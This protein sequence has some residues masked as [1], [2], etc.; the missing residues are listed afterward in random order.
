M[1][2][3]LLRQYNVACDFLGEAYEKIVLVL[4][5]YGLCTGPYLE[6]IKNGWIKFASQVIVRHSTEAT[7]KAWCVKWM[8]YKLCAFFAWMVDQPLPTCPAEFAGDVPGALVGGRVMKCLRVWKRE[9]WEHGDNVMKGKWLGLGQSLKLAKRGMPRPDELMAISTIVK[10]F[11][12][13]T[14]SPIIKQFP[15]VSLDADPT[16]AERSN[17]LRRLSSI[18]FEDERDIGL[19]HSLQYEDQYIRL[20]RWYVR[21]VMSDLDLSRCDDGRPRSLSRSATFISS[22]SGLGQ[23]GSIFG[24]EGNIQK[25][26]WDNL[27]LA[28]EFE[29]I[30]LPTDESIMPIYSVRVDRERTGLC[31]D[32]DAAGAYANY[33]FVQLQCLGR[34][35]RSVDEGSH[36]SILAPVI[37]ALKVRVI[38]KGSGDVVMLLK[39][40][41]DAMRRYLTGMGQ[42]IVGKI[43]DESNLAY[44]GFPDHQK[45]ERYLSVDYEDST[46]NLGQIWSREISEQIFG[47]CHVWEEKRS[48]WRQTLYGGRVKAAE[49]TDKKKAW[50]SRCGLGAVEQAEYDQCTVPT[51]MQNGQLMG[52]I[53]SFPI[54]CLAN[55]FAL[56]MTKM[57][58]DGRWYDPCTVRIVV[59]G[60]DGALVTT[61]AGYGF[62]SQLATAMGFPPSVGKV[63]YSADFF[64]FNSRIFQ[65]RWTQSL[66]DFVM[67]R[68]RHQVLIGV[69]F[70]HVGLLDGKHRTGE[71][72]ALSELFSSHLGFSIGG[73]QRTLLRFGRWDQRIWIMQH[74]HKHLLM[75]PDVYAQIRG[76]PW[77]VPACL[78]GLGLRPLYRDFQRS[79]SD[80]GPRPRYETCMTIT[81]H[82]TEWILGPDDRSCRACEALLVRVVKRDVEIP[83]LKLVDLEVLEIPKELRIHAQREVRHWPRDIVECEWNDDPSSDL[84]LWAN[85]TEAQR[86]V[87][88]LIERYKSRGRGGSMK[89]DDVI[90]RRFTTRLKAFWRR[91]DNDCCLAPEGLVAFHDLAIDERTLWNVTLDQDRLDRLCYTRVIEA[92]L[93]RN[94]ETAIVPL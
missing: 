3:T 58:G 2:R 81:K 56:W 11:K 10:T 4:C 26:R 84:C 43:E 20:C 5:S 32:L 49:M 41:Q 35:L 19:D 66:A 28:W 74:L 24:D 76:I 48:L 30:R 14:Q 59:N 21:E 8:K 7:V 86:R 29:P 34:A 27:D 78:G 36:V 83:R 57:I 60:D 55:G 39:P 87:N 88:G 23:L 72:V 54:L 47:T 33:R 70:I 75:R 63:Y 45:G 92:Q 18:V 89:Q 6:L 50:L 80:T 25:G 1:K 62:W 9:W 79:S 15:V 31:V 82:P 12:K 53:V 52:N 85:P 64:D 16:S 69:R 67:G 61:D 22:R 77:F 65:P 17:L 44:I 51:P 37:E 90:V 91:W 94:P 46:N 71:K 93:R 42:F 13:L 73:L 40:E 38:S 68:P